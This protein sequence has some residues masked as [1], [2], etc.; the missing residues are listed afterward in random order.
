MWSLGCVIYELTSLK[1]P[2]LAKDIGTLQNKVIKGEY[3][4]IPRHFSA[5]LGEVLSYCLVLDPEKRWSAEE[6]LAHKGF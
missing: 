5:E 4:K 6:L 3:P 2:F 1:P